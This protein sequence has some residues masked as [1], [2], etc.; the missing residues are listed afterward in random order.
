MEKKSIEDA[1][2]ALQAKSNIRFSVLKFD[3]SENEKLDKMAHDALCTF[4]QASRKFLLKKM[5]EFKVAV[6]MGVEDIDEAKRSISGARKKMEEAKSLA[7]LFLVTD[8][9]E[10][11]FKVFQTLVDGQAELLRATAQVKPSAVVDDAPQA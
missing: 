1:L 5:D 11:M 8:K 2:T 10:D 3:D 6:E 9:F 7:L 4:L